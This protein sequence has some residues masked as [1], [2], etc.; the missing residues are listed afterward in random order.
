[1]SGGAKDFFEQIAVK[2]E[3]GA[4]GA[5][6]LAEEMSKMDGV[7]ALQTYV[8]KLEEAGVNQQQMSFYLESMG[9]DLTGLIP[10]L[11]DGGKLW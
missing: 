10:I 3:S 1:G 5:K 9:S 4:E 7:E 8:D 6:K 2:T 11:Q